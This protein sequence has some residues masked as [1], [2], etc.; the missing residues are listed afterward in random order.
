MPYNYH[1]TPRMHHAT[2]A[3]RHACIMQLQQNACHATHHEAHKVDPEDRPEERVGRAHH[4][5]QHCAQ[6]LLPF[7]HGLYAAFLNDACRTISG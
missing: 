3:K 2:T 7:E 4:E 5:G 1:K 6:V